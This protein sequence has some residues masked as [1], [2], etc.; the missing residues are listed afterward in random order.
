[1]TQVTINSAGVTAERLRLVAVRC[2]YCGRR[3]SLDIPA[4]TPYV[5]VCPRCSGKIEGKA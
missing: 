5:G 3:Q 4:G 1:M 2:A